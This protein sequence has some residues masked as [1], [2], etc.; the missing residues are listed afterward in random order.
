MTKA[1]N[2][3]F[4][5]DLG[6]PKATAEKMTAGIPDT[7][8]ETP[9]AEI[10]EAF[11]TITTHQTELFTN[12]EDYKK[13]IKDAGDKKLG[14]AMTK[15]EKKIISISGLKADEIVGKKYDEIVELAWKK[16]STSGDKGTAEVQAELIKVSE[17]LKK[18]R[19]EE[20]PAIKSQV[21]AE[22]LSFKT[23][24][25]LTKLVGTLKL[26]AGVDMDDALILIRQKAEK[27]GYKV[28]V[29]DKMNV[30][31][32]DAEGGKIMTEDKKAFRSNSDILGALL[33]GQIEKSKADDKDEKQHIIKTDDKDDKQKTG[34]QG[35]TT[36]HNLEKARKHAEKLAETKDTGAGS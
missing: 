32:T 3:K 2:I 5:M 22:K 30:T 25:A 1:Q 10:D 29:D 15:A 35:L 11:Q 26:R 31:F 24:A 12:G 33:G 23:E 14:E 34:Q 21:E 7:A 6:I 17:E 28:T 36:N 19:E 20:I 27:A 9:Q 4:L 8:T 18:V 16:V 13:A